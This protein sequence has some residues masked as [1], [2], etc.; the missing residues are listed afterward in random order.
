MPLNAR[1]FIY[2]YY[3]VVD[4]FQVFCAIPQSSMNK[5][6]VLSMLPFPIQKKFLY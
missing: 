1:Y 3:R 5:G 4:V 6:I 2:R